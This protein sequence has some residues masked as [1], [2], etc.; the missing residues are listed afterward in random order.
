LAR[1]RRVFEL[2]CLGY[3]I[4]QIVEKLAEE[5]KR[6]SENT[7]KA[8]LHSA[9]AGEF[10]EELQRQ[11]FA[12]IALSRSRRL[13]LEFRDRMIE[14]FTP[15]KSPDVAVNM[16]N[17]IQLQGEQPLSE[18]L[19]KYDAILNEEAQAGVPKQNLRADGSEKQVSEA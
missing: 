5:G 15:R 1:R 14:R 18:L 9:D 8:D 12:D 4:P 2:R 10:L 17:N 3:K 19:A 11:Q 16:Q 13:K 7:I 6:W